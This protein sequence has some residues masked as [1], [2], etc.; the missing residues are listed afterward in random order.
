MAFRVEF[1][2]DEVERLSLINPTSGETLDRP[3]RMFIYPSKHFVLPEERIAGAVDELKR[4]L[5]QRLSLFKEQGQA[6]RGPA[7]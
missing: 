1:W 3:Q 6:A 5:Q 4:E 2:G 7:P